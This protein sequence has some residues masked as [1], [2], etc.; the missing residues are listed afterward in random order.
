MSAL[1]QAQGV[2]RRAHQLLRLRQRQPLQEEVIC[3]PRTAVRPCAP[4][5]WRAREKGVQPRPG[6]PSF[7]LLQGNRDCA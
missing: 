2:R 3:A 5:G 4:A 7:S 6:A 1:P